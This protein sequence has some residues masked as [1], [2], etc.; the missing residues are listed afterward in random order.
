[1]DFYRNLS[2][3]ACETLGLSKSL[4]A[5]RTR[6]AFTPPQGRRRSAGASSEI[7]DFLAKVE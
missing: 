4:N 1:M 2:P 6:L 3:L 5:G 7:A